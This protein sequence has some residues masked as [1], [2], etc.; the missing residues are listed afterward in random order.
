MTV[1]AAHLGG[2]NLWDDV[3]R[4]IAGKYDNLYMDVG[5]VAR[6][7]EDDILLK[8]IRQQG[9]EKVLFGSDCPWDDPANEI[10]MINRLPLSNEEKGLIFHKNAERLLG[11]ERG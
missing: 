10:A 9:A 3:L 6:Y 11:I 1:V 5:V 8:I 7:I 2:M 4:H